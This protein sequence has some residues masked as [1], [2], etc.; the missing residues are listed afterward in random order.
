MNITIRKIYNQTGTE[1]GAQ[2]SAGINAHTT[3]EQKAEIEPILRA[4]V[5][6]NLPYTGQL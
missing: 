5:M 4:Y 1:T 2:L 6:N 3:A